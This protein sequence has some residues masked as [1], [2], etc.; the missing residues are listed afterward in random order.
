M[1]RERCPLTVKST[2]LLFYNSEQALLNVVGSGRHDL[3]S[4]AFQ[5]VSEEKIPILV[6]MLYDDL[7]RLGGWMV[8][9]AGVSRE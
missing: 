5:R 8:R 3:A 2:A 6:E 7:A 4:A 1:S 9:L